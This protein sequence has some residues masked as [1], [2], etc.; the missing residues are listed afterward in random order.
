MRDC[1]L[2]NA[3]SFCCFFLCCTAAKLLAQLKEEKSEAGNLSAQMS[4][5]RLEWSRRQD[6]GPTGWTLLNQ[7]VACR[8]TGQNSGWFIPR[9]DLVDQVDQVYLE[10]RFHKWCEEDPKVAVYKAEELD[11][12][13]WVN[14]PAGQIYVREVPPPLVVTC[15]FNRVDDEGAEAVF[16]TASG[17]VMLQIERVKMKLITMEGL[18]KTVAMAVAAQDRVQSCNREVC[19]VLEGQPH[20]YS[21]VTV[22]ELYWEKLRAYHARSK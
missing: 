4:G 14:Y 21:T 12:A 5:H 20:M 1:C 13:F 10:C 19:A 8:N 11:H 9:F 16:T 22:P 15:S 2:S 17:C 6:A 3:Y 7:A 18:A